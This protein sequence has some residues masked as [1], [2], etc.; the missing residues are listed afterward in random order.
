MAWFY[1]SSHP[2]HQGIV[3]VERVLVVHRSALSFE[4]WVH[5]FEPRT[6][7]DP[8]QIVRTEVCPCLFKS[9]NV[10]LINRRAVLYSKPFE[11]AVAIIDVLFDL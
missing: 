11:I 8:Q 5:G 6:V 9:H 10:R 2:G 4:G 3:I 1:L 7:F